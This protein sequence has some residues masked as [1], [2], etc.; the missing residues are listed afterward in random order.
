[1]G[2]AR[3]NLDQLEGFQ[4]QELSKVKHMLLSAETALETE[5]RTRQELERK[6]KSQE[7]LIKEAAA[8]APALAKEEELNRRI[9]AL[10]VGSA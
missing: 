4:N 6:Q 3:S 8:D 10:T 2:E 1:M 9:Q 5:K 7:A